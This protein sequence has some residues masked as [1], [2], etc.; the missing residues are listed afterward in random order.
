MLLNKRVV[1]VYSA[2]RFNI[3]IITVQKLPMCVPVGRVF[4]LVI[5]FNVVYVARAF[6]KTGA[7]AA[8]RDD[9]SLF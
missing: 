7:A 9:R 5:Y 1:W 8:C 6:R 4:T 2:L 3:R